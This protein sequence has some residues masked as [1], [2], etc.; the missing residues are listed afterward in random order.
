M[1]AIKNMFLVMLM[2]VSS[3]SFASCSDK[4]DDEP[5]NPYASAIVGTWK[6][7]HH[8]STTYWVE[9][10]FQT[11]KIIFNA[12]GTCSESG[13]FKI[14]SGTY[15]VTDK[16]ITCYVGGYIICQYD[17]ISIQ[18]GIAI[19]DMYAGTDTSTKISIKCKKI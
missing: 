15:K 19:F 14:S 7:T 18:N 9:W 3:I 10:P 2:I 6:I 17:I 16:H 11:T 5:Q 8:G 13:Y 4:E 1:K 12:D